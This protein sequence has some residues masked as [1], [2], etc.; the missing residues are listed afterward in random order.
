MA[1]IYDPG[2]QTFN[3]PKRFRSKEDPTE[4]RP[5]INDFVPDI[6]N[7]GGRY[8]KPNQDLLPMGFNAALFESASAP[9]GFFREGL[10]SIKRSRE[11]DFF[12]QLEGLIGQG[13]QSFQ[14]NLPQIQKF[15]G[16]QADLGQRLQNQGAAGL[17]ASNQSFIDAL[18]QLGGFENGIEVNRLRQLTDPNSTS[19]GLSDELKSLISKERDLSIERS[20]IGIEDA[21][22]EL[23]SVRQARA[24]ARGLADSSVSERGTA[25]VQ[26]QLM[27][28]LEG[29]RLAAEQ[30]GLEREAQLRGLSLQ[31]RG[32]QQ[33]GLLNTLQSLIQASSTQAGASAQA[34]QNFLSQLGQGSELAG[35]FGGPG[36]QAI[37]Q[38]LFAGATSPLQ[39]FIQQNLTNELDALRIASGSGGQQSGGGGGIASTIGKGLGGLLGGGIA[40]VFKL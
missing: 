2:K 22:K 21:F 14:Q 37:L 6:E 16:Q 10:R 17:Q 1:L 30:Q 24:A 32:Q 36:G 34:G 25:D 11:S 39:A 5:Q 27:Q 12:K 35:Q 18:S 7:P 29:A 40:K 26:N 33:S 9:K 23:D 15:I 38:Q 28:Q 13:T 31:E 8:L 20:K 3:I 4:F 19:L